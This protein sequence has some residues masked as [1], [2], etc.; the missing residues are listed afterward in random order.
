MSPKFEQRI[1]DILL[2]FCTYPVALAADIKV[3]LVVS[4]SEKDR[5][6]LRFLWVNDVASDPPEIRVL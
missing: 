6:A 1:L 2:R 3:F 5:D 4:I